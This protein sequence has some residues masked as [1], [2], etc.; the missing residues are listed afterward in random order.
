VSPFDAE[1]LKKPLH[2]SSF[3][4]YGKRRAFP[5]GI[6]FAAGPFIKPETS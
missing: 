2:W 3:H 6:L 1:S 5:D 4:L